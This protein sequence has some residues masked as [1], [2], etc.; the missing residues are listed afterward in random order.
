[1]EEENRRHLKQGSYSSFLVLFLIAAVV[2][3]N[4]IVGQLPT[5]FYT[6]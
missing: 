3:V 4:L 6:D 2:I 5:T 1:M